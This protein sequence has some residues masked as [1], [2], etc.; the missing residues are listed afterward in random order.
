MTQRPTN[1][2]GTPAR[3]QRFVVTHPHA[4]GIDSLS[5]KPG[6]ARFP[7]TEFGGPFRGFQPVKHQVNHG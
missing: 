7:I 3:P 6:S 2:P 5:H 4:A 1:D